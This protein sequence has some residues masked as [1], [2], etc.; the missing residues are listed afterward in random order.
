MGVSGASTLQ[1]RKLFEGSNDRPGHDVRGIL[2]FSSV[3]DQEGDYRSGDGLQ[4]PDI[5]QCDYGALRCDCLAVDGIA[6]PAV[7]LTG[8]SQ[9]S[10]AYSAMV[11]SDEN[12]AIRATLRMPARAH[13]EPA[14]QRASMLRC[15]A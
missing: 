3:P 12:H 5:V 1:R 4:Q 2:I 7:T 11:R 8:T 9:I 15:A 10:W 14:C 6:A 13:A